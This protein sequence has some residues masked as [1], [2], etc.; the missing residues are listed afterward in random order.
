LSF[1]YIIVDD[2]IYVTL[3]YIL[4]CKTREI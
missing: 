1:E 3:L 2:K 4:Y